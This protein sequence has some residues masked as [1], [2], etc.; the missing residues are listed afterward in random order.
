MLCLSG[1]RDGRPRQVRFADELVQSTSTLNKDD[2]PSGIQQ[3]ML[4]M[5]GQRLPEAQVCRDHNH[6]NRITS[7]HVRDIW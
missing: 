1:E 3:F 5:A 7:A 6:H 4:K 2:A